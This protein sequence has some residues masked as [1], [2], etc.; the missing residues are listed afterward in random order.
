MMEYRKLGLTDLNMSVIGYGAWA[1]GG[2]P[3][4]TVDDDAASLKA[5]AKAADL[6][7]TFFDTAPVY[8]FGRSEKL[9][10]KALGA[11]RADVVIATKCGLSWKSEH[12]ESIYR[13]SSAGRIR[14]EVDESLRR[15]KTDYIDL[16]QVHWP[17]PDTP[18]EETMRALEEIRSS[19]KVRALGVSNFS[20]GQLAESLAV[21]R[22]DACQPKYNMFDRS[23][24]ADLV[25]FCVE[26]DIGIVCYSPLD[27]GVLTGKYDEQMIFEDWRRVGGEFKGET[28]REKIRK[29]KA[30][31]AVAEA[32]G[33]TLTQLVIRWTID[34]QGITSAIVGAN[35]EAQASENAGAIE[36]ALSDKALAS[37][38]G[39]LEGT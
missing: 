22:I 1:I 32:Q 18:L 20:T 33:M 29:V 15:L 27:S 5:I 34:R 7:V 28:Y 12:F 14:R 36:R 11:R 38:M 24:E 19:G 23:I 39:I 8:G 25:P 13:D 16:Y 30:L 10:G 35:T 26:R 9:I 17:D 2:Y 31:K 6:G 3:F 4:W 37:V 21:T